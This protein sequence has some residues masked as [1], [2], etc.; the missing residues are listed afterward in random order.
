MLK[1]TGNLA[2]SSNRTLL[3]IN[4]QWSVTLQEGFATG[5][6]QPVNVFCILGVGW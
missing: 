2:S 4:K 1:E 5:S 3:I 6:R